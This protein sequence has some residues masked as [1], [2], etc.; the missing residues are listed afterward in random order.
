VAS[1]SSTVTFPVTVS[2]LLQ[3]GMSVSD[4]LGYIPSGSYIGNVGTD[5]ITLVNAHG[6]AVNATGSSHTDTVSFPGPTSVGWTYVNDVAGSTLTIDRTNEL[7]SPTVSAT[8]VTAGTGSVTVKDPVN[9]AGGLAVTGTPTA[10]QTIV[11]TSTTAA[12]W[13][14]P[15][16]GVL[17]GPAGGVLG[18]DY[19]NPTF[20]SGLT[21][22]LS[23]SGTYDIPTAAS[24]LRITCVGGGGGGGGGGAALVNMAQVGGAGG[25]AGVTSVQVVP[26]STNTQLVVHVGTPGTGGVGAKGGGDTAGGAGGGGGPSSV[27]GSGISVRGG[28]GGGGQ[29][30][31]GASTTAVHGAAYGAPGNVYTATASGGSGG[32]SG[33]DGGFPVSLSTGGGGGG[34]TGGSSLGGGGGSAG[35][36]SGLASAGK[37]GGNSSTSGGTGA[38][39]TAMGGPGGGGGGGVLGGAGGAGGA[40]APGYVIIEVVG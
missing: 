3:Q 29:A 5:T 30:G 22:V 6:S 24:V 19:P 11:A 2:S 20:A 18:G 26:V 21:T 14:A 37:T 33:L 36:P 15:P 27:T 31:Q 32:S 35:S 28:G 4:S 17:T 39:A 9:Y 1:G 7:I 13:G 8:P 10:G 16:A 25:A 23:A 12:Q 38:S 34:G 40:G